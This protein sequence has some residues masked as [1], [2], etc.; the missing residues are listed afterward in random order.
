MIKLRRLPVLG[1]MTAAAFCEFLLLSFR[2]NQFCKLPQMHIF[3]ATYTGIGEVA[4]LDFLPAIIHSKQQVT[5]STLHRAMLSFQGKFGLA[6]IENYPIPTFHIVTKLASVRTY[7]FVHFSFVGI[8]MT[9]QTAPGFKTDTGRRQ[10]LFGLGFY[11][12]G[13]TR[14]RPMAPRQWIVAF[15]M[16]L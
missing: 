16:A 3:M 14:H 2:Y 7:I 9:A 8:F 13:I 12:A 11:M 1:N 10:F 4:K 5:S 6:M 15:L